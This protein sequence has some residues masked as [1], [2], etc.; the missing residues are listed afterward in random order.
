M[1]MIILHQSI[2]SELCQVEDLYVQLDPFWPIWSEFCQV[3]DF[4]ILKVQP[5]PAEQFGGEAKVG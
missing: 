1:L 2:Q 3:E 5:D 4:W